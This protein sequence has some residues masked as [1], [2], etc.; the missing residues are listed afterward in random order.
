MDLKPNTTGQL[1]NAT[2]FHLATPLDAQALSVNGTYRAAS[3]DTEGFIHCCTA[4]Q[5]PGVIQRY[6]ADAQNV[7]VLTIET[8]LLKAELVYENT[9]GGEALF[10]H[11]YGE[12]NQEAVT[13]TEALNRT[14]IVDIANAGQI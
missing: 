3:L 10:P 2:I 13:S 6:Y 12:I 9:V 14:R 7:V 5:L 4:D 1:L 11:V 8:A